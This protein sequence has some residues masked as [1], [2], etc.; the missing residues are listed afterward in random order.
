MFPAKHTLLQ[1][2]LLHQEW[3]DAEHWRSMDA[4]PSALEDCVLRERLYHIH[5]VQHAFLSIVR[6]EKAI[7]P[8]FEDFL[9]PAL[10]REYARRY[11]REMAAFIQSVAA[12]RLD[13]MLIIP[14][15]KDPPIEITV[16]QALTQAVMHSQSH[17][18]QNAVRFRE[19]GGEPP[20][21]D[22]IAWYWKGRPAARWE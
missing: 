5:L 16:A 10:L 3:A 2:L 17:R 7:F 12:E 21:T 13:A 14:W 18:G 8:K 15:F 1:D 20:M 9:N 11:H 22:L 4:L 19:L 6:G